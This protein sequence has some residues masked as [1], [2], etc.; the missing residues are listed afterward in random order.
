M[1]HAY[2]SAPQSLTYLVTMVSKKYEGVV[3]QLSS[4]FLLPR[5]EGIAYRNRTC[6][7]LHGM[8][9]SCFHDDVGK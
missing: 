5:L 7:C 3:E 4:W 8:S 1:S 9:F 2:M 6:Q